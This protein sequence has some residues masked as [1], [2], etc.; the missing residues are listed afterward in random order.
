M[1][2]T[3]EMRD[4]VR[5]RIERLAREERGVRSKLIWFRA[6]SQVAVAAGVAFPI[7]AG[8]TLL[9][10]A[11]SALPVGSGGSLWG[12]VSGGLALA[13]GLMTGLHK[14]LKCEA[15]QAESRRTVHA[16]RSL[17]EDFEATSVLNADELGPAVMALEARRRELRLDAFEVP[18]AL[19]AA[20]G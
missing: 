18:P 3:V 19:P 7:L 13:A 10:G 2:S 17:I 11:A 4:F 14:G 1:S 5:G 9:A 8:S 16:L 20:A 15:Y 12:A 6:F